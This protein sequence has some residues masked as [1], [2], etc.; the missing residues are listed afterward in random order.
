MLKNTKRFKKL[1]TL[2][3]EDLQQII[4][5]GGNKAPS[6]SL[7]GPFNLN[8]ILSSNYFYPYQSN[9]F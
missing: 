3:E 1:Q 4:A 2:S 6:F 8:I 9:Y 5:A 7:C